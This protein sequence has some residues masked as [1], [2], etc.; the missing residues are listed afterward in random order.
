MVTPEQRCSDATI[1]HSGPYCSSLRRQ[2]NSHSITDAEQ[3]AAYLP[4]GCGRLE[5]ANAPDPTGT[6]LA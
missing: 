6:L 5:P 2:D 4:G 1:A 3:A